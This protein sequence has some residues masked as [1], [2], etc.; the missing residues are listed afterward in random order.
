MGREKLKKRLEKTRDLKSQQMID[1]L[2]K[3]WPQLETLGVDMD[4]VIDK[5]E[6]DPHYFETLSERAKKNPDNF[7]NVPKIAGV[8]SKIPG[9]APEEDNLIKN[10][11]NLSIESEKKSE[12]IVNDGSG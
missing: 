10:T 7:T 6:D 8:I 2:L 5:M 9:K 11:S 12:E 3:N 4:F 1:H